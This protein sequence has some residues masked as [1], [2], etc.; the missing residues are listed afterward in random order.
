MNPTGSDTPTPRTDNAERYRDGLMQSDTVV[1]AS[2]ARALERELIAARADAER[3]REM[4]GKYLTPAFTAQLLNMPLLPSGR[5]SLESWIDAHVD[6][7]IAAA[8]KP[9]G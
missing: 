6:A 7:S 2:F 9:S 4:R 1:L 3:W 8:S 5:H